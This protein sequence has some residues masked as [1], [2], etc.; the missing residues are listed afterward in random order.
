MWLG[1]GV[2]RIGGV[3]TLDFPPMAM[4]VLQIERCHHFHYFADFFLK[5]WAY[6]SPAD[7]C[8]RCFLYNGD[9]NI[10]SY[11]SSVRNKIYRY[12]ISL[13]KLSLE[14]FVFDGKL[15]TIFKK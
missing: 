1:I 14:G 12:Y 7:L 3:D 11:V 4:S 6:N 5:T 10:C 13:P 15:G 2:F 8:S 9:L